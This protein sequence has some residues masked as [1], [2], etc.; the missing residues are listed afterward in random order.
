MEP[1]EPPLRAWPTG[2]GR[3]GVMFTQCILECAGNHVVSL[4]PLYPPPLPHS[5]I[6]HL[7]PR[8]TVS[9]AQAT[10]GC[11]STLSWRRKILLKFL[12]PEESG[13]ILIQPKWNEDEIVK[14]DR[15]FICFIYLFDF[16]LPPSAPQCLSELND[17]LYCSLS[18]LWI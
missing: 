2:Q 5:P 3:S 18:N 7:H 15:C 1:Q 14:W 11:N 9:Q 10:S 13:E 4:C 8:L 6:L 17:C 16:F 12:R